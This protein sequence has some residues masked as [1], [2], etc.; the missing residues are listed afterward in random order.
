VFREQVALHYRTKGYRV[1]ESVKVRG[2][3]GTVF[4]CDLVVQGPLGNL[5]VDFSEDG[6]GL[7][8][9][10]LRRKA[11]EL[12]AT[13]VLAAPRFTPA[14]RPLAL[15]VGVVLLDEDALRDAPAPAPPAPAPEPHPWPERAVAEA[16]KAPAAWPGQRRPE[17]GAWE[18]RDVDEI[19]QELSVPVPAPEERT[20]DPVAVSLWR[21][22][23]GP[24]RGTRADRERFAWLRPPAPEAA[25][26][27]PGEPVQ[28]P[29]APKE[30]R[31]GA[32]GA[33]TTAPPVAPPATRSAAAPGAGPSFQDPPAS[34]RTVE[35]S[36]AGPGGP[37]V[38]AGE[39]AP[40]R[41]RP[42]SVP[43]AGVGGHLP[44]HRPSPP[45]AD[46]QRLG[47]RP[48]P[49]PR[50]AAPLLSRAQAAQAAVVGVVSGLVVL[51]GLVWLLF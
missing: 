20:I 28:A 4:P 22:P 49:R 25:G 51:G 5:V 3:S 35:A 31:P 42:S 8:M 41:S 23:P 29:A 21:R 1:E 32:P 39:G 11:K 6:D 17:E 47:V 43:A 50:R 34:G 16:A 44:E 13:P 9:G 15:R 24:V 26:Q 40:P 46:E 18:A 33:A 48:R 14:L 38:D 37:P 19:V 27:A 36:G 7:E 45:Q 12:G 30:A 10:G 2:D